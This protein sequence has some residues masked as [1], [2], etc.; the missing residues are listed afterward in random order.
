MILRAGTPKYFS[1]GADINEMSSRTFTTAI[2]EDFF[3][4]GWARVAQCRKPV[5][6]AVS[7]LALGGGCE[8]ALMCDVIVASDTAEFGLP[9]VRLGIFPGAG[10]TQRLARQVGKSKAMEMILTGDI[11]LTASE[12]LSHEEWRGV[13][14]VPES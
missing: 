7:G 8:L 6:A 11:N 1:V 5:I 4:V 13:K 2:D 10:G 3:T 14:L 12:A 9:E